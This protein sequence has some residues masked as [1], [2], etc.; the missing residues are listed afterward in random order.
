MPLNISEF[1]LQDEEY[2]L[3]NLGAEFHRTNRGGLITFHGPGQLVVY[4]VL[5]LNHFRPS[6][7]WYI[8][9]LEQTIINT[10][11][12]FGI[13]AQ[14]TTDTGVWVEDRKIASIGECALD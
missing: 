3:K 11:R 12:R 9:T 8:A 7:K 1:S 14:T 4:P 2:R 13:Q 6:M 5:N 10:C